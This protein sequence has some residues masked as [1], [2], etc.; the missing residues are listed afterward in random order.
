VPAVALGLYLPLIPTRIPG[1][2]WVVITS[3]T[4]C[5]GQCC[6]SQWLLCVL[7]LLPHSWF[8]S[9]VTQTHIACYFLCW[10]QQSRQCKCV[11][12]IPPPPYRRSL[13]AVRVVF[14][15]PVPICACVPYYRRVKSSFCAINFLHGLDLCSVGLGGFFCFY[16][17]VYFDWQSSPAPL[18]GS[19]HHVPTCCPLC[20]TYRVE[21]LVGRKVR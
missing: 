5:F 20:K 9:R 2:F 17:G 15:L 19:T 13:P 21:L 6:S 10:K 11:M 1:S 16:P 7:A 8:V 18:S 3:L 12:C 4:P 14:I